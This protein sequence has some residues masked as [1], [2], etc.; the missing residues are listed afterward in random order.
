M[1]EEKKKITM[2]SPPF[3]AGDMPGSMDLA[4]KEA[5]AAEK[6]VPQ[7][8]VPEHMAEA[9]PAPIAHAPAPEHD[10][11]PTPKKYEESEAAPQ[12]P[13]TVQEN[14]TPAAS[15]PLFVKIDKYHNIVKNIQKLKSY[16]LGMRDAIDALAE[17]EKELQNGLGVVNRALDNFNQVIGLLDAKLLRLQGIENPDVGVPK[18]MDDYIKNVYDQIDKIKQ[19]IKS[20]P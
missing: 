1:A 15:P 3:P 4:P 8:P 7:P 10:I 18:E 20:M 13:E 19:G 14:I 17:I 9:P 2:P 5:R 6:P 11:L 12:G 16:S